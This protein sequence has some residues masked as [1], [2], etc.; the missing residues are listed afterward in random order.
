MSKTL[1]SQKTP[2][3]RKQQLDWYK[4]TYDYFI[5]Q[6]MS[7]KKSDDTLKCLQAANG[8][9]DMNTLKYVSEPLRAGK[10]GLPGDLPGVLRNTDFITPIK[11]RNIGEYIELPY[12]YFVKVNNTDAV[13][14]R[15]N[16]IK[17]AVGKLMKQAFTNLMA[18]G[19]KNIDVNNND[20]PNIKEFADKFS[21]EWID[22][23]A[24][25]GQHILNLINDL[26]DF[27]TQRVQ[28]FYYWWATE[29]FY[30]YR[31]I[32]NNELFREVVSPLDAFPIPNGEQFVED[33]DAFVI[34]RKKSWNQFLDENHDDISDA[35]RTYIEELNNS[36]S[37]TGRLATKAKFLRTRTDVEGVFKSD[38]TSQ[39][40]EI[41]FSDNVNDIDECLIIWKTEEP[42]NILTYENSIGETKITEVSSDY[43]LNTV[44]GDISI[45]RDWKQVVYIGKRFGPE[46]RGLYLKP[47]KCIVQRYDKASK[48]CKLPVGGK[49]GILVNV[50][51]NPIPMRIVP[52]LAMDRFFYLQI[53]RTIAKYKSDIWLMPKGMISDDEAGTAQQKYFYM[54]AD[55]MLVYD[56]TLVDFNTVVQGFRVVGNPGLER[57]LKTLIELRVANKNEA[58]DLANM[59]DERYGAVSTQQTV[60]NAQQNIYRAKLG[61]TL[62]ITMYN[63]TLEREHL[64]DLE[65]SKYAWINGKTET[66]FDKNTNIPILVEVDPIT[67]LETDYGVFVRNSKAEEKKFEDYRNLA[68]SAGQNGDFELASSVINAESTPELRRIVKEFTDAK[69]EFDMAM[70]ERKNDAIRYAADKAS[71]DKAAEL[72]MEH[73]IATERN[74]A[75][76]EAAYVNAI[77]FND[78]TKG[79][80]TYTDDEILAIAKARMAE[81]AQARADRA[82]AHK[83]KIDNEK[84]K[85]GKNKAKS[86]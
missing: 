1:P 74:D 83:E 61:S 58:W 64:A 43:E 63:K 48:R 77:G 8:I 81:R 50:P 66:Y 17:V 25:E 29:E 21:K 40:S 85:I 39:E 52:Y 56:E 73:T 13:F 7:L 67:H 27:D 75:N 36:Y 20:I 65:F 16:D 22:S 44:N 34:R 71:A 45:K 38:G 68:F 53:E 19:D 35:D 11:E 30:T 32:R 26:T 76:I 31:Y 59:N 62:M 57:Y 23:R 55:N 24:E 3:A 70:E 18:K 42:V 37:S 51:R 82:Q 15:T 80:N 6:S 4:P 5:E 9:I 12:K 2:V 46:D 47:T 49:Q 84:L 60:T 72:E 86:K 14:K 79:E 41:S 78:E 28:N 10:E 54:L 33:Y 69:R